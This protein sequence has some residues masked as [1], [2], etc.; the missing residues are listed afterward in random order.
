MKDYYEILGLK[1]GA[2]EEEVKSAYRK[3]AMK[4]HP[5]KN[6][7]SKEA[8]G[9]FK[10]INEAYAVLSDKEKRKQYDMFGAEGFHQRF[11]QE[12]IFR[13][14]D[15]GEIFREFGFGDD[16]FSRLFGAEFRSARS[17]HGGVY[18]HSPYDFHGIFSDTDVFEASKR[19]PPKGQ[20]L[21]Y[22]LEI[23]L[24]EVAKGGQRR[25]SFQR[26]GHLV[27]GNVRIP[28]GIECGKKLRISGKGLRDPTGGPPGDLYCRIRV[29]PHPTFSREGDD[30]TIE[31]EIRFSEAALGTELMVPTIDGK[32]LDVKVPA[33]TKNGAGLR[34][35]GHGLPRFNGK[36]KGDQY[37][38]I[39]IAI[40]KTLTEQQ[41][42][43][44]DALQREGL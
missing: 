18:R 3:L 13:G 25:I 29:T 38:K 31:R 16:V 37:V 4:Y 22:D 28:E 21:I 8:E 36:G 14:F 32:S 27:S 6:Q 5:D 19:Q 44:I 39:K 41:K 10:E 40:P 26:D 9:R 2:S 17:Q 33:G 23:S 12:D 7:G 20:D 42:E 1:R 11:S 15:F 30:L 24:E 34:I 35:K 43:L